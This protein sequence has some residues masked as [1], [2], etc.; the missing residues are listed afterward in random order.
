VVLPLRGS[1]EVLGVLLAD[2]LREGVEL[3]AR[4]Q[5]LRR[6]AVRA[7]QALDRARTIEREA[8]Q[9]AS[10]RRASD[11][12]RAALG[13]REGLIDALDGG[14]FEADLRGNLTRVSAGFA[15]L[16]GGEEGALKGVRLAEL[17]AHG[18][19][20]ALTDLF[21]RVLRSGRSVRRASWAL[22]VPRGGVCQVE[23]ALGLLRDERGDPSGYFGLM[24]ERGRPPTAG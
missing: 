2:D 8:R 9:G 17:A 11:L 12:L 1:Q 20:E 3:G 24:T 23:L 4:L 21:G 22:V 13:A 7:G 19:E 14:Y 18:G 10:V 6:I 5:A 16:A 15:R